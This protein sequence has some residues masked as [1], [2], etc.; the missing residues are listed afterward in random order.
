MDEKKI[1]EGV[2]LI[3]E[4]IGEDL[5]REG[6]VRTPERVA[7]MYMDI[8]GGTGVDPEKK[9]HLY[10]TCNKDEMIIL[11]DIPFFSMCEH[12]LLPFFGKVHIA[13]IPK[14]NKVAG[15]STLLEVVDLLSKRLQIQE[16][17]TT[18][19]ADFIVKM[20]DPLGVLV[21]IEAQQLCLY[22][23]GLKKTGVKTVTSAIR[24]VMENAATRSEALSLIESGDRNI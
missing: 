20:I 13:Y 15:F 18:Q 16:R 6:L 3:L 12:H 24:G 9:I 23:R 22:M 8:L 17:L 19:I 10:T 14:N 7:K 11:K 21:I 4:G 1:M 5:N 2:K